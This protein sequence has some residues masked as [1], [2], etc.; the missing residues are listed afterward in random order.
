MQG[1]GWG[2]RPPQSPHIRHIHGH[3]QVV[4]EHLFSILRAQL[5]LQLGS[6][7]RMDGLPGSP[8]SQQRS[9]L[10]TV[11][12]AVESAAA[13]R[14]LEDPMGQCSGRACRNGMW[15]GL[16]GLMARVWPTPTST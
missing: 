14:G 4:T 13:T 6:V 10:G 11:R 8:C 1:W 15:W 2:T 5:G 16:G 9:C 7:V 12:Q 3:L